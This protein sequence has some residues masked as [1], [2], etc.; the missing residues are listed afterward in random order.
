MDTD[1]KKCPYCAEE[2]LKT[3]IKCKY[4]K[5]DLNN[6]QAKGAQIPQNGQGTYTYAD[7]SKYVGEWKD[8]K[9][10]GQGTY[11]WADGNK[12]VGEWKDDKRHG[13][14]TFT[15]TD[16]EKYVGEFK[17][18]K[19]HGQGIHT[20]ADGS[21]YVGEFKDNKSHGQGIY[22]YADG[23][24]YD[25]EWRNDKPHG[26]GIYTDADGREILKIC[27][28]C[29]E[30]VKQEARKCKHCGEDLTLLVNMIDF[31]SGG[32]EVVKGVS[33]LFNI[34]WKTFLVILTSLFF[35]YACTMSMLDQPLF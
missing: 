24:K 18:D 29:G 27:P 11:T 19:L 5:E 16:G 6:P 8:G 3:A 33:T 9:R 20:Y 22:T 25:G 1:M 30:E 34:I 17:D 15:S 28:E 4:C 12:N 13:Q 32:R 14:G 21:E 35:M 26:Q 23:R 7:G 31:G 10:H 2:I